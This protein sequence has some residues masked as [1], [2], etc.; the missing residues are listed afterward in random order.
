[1]GPTNKTRAERELEKVEKKRAMKDSGQSGIEIGHA[2]VKRNER[3][4]RVPEIIRA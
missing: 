3:N 2:L 1:L 4:D